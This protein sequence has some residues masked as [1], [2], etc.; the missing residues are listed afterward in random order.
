LLPGMDEDRLRG[1]C[2]TVTAWLAFPYQLADGH[3]AIISASAGATNSFSSGREAEVLLSHADM[4]L[5]AAKQIT[6]NGVALFTPDM[7]DRLRERQAMDA[8]LRRA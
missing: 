7:D 2:T 4:A 6:G 5:S 8:A 3:Q 1:F